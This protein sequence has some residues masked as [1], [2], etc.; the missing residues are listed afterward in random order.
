[1]Q[2]KFFPSPSAK[3]AQSLNFANYF[4]VLIDGKIREIVI[5]KNQEIFI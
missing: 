3:A 2:A 5:T 4:V 1:M